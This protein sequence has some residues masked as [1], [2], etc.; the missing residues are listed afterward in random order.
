MAVRGEKMNFTLTELLLVITIICIVA[1]LLMPALQGALESSRQASCAN[2][3]RLCG[4]GIRSY[5]DDWRGHYPLAGKG[6]TTFWTSYACGTTGGTAYVDRSALYCPANPHYA[7]CTTGSGGGSFRVGPAGTFGGYGMY[8]ANIDN[9]YAARKFDFYSTEGTYPKADYYQY[10]VLARV[11][12]PSA[13]PLLADTVSLKNTDPAAYGRMVITFLPNSH[14][15][16]YSSIIQTLHRGRADLLFFDGHAQGLD[17]VGMYNTRLH[18][19]H[20]ADQFL[21]PMDLPVPR[22]Y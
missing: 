6:C 22:L 11:R 8:Q 18:I 20:Y 15:T 3:L 9:K 1:A 19:D 21:N 7:V 12:E 17:P 10:Y 2:N 4:V 5:A 16:S 13:T 14:A